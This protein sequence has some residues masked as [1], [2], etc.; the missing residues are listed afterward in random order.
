MLAARKRP[1]LLINDRPPPGLH[2]LQID[3]VSTDDYSG[4]V[5]AAQLIA[6]KLAGPLGSL[7]RLS[8]KQPT[9][10]EEKRVTSLDRKM[11]PHAPFPIKAPPDWKIAL[12]SGPPTDS[13]SNQR[14]AGF[15][16]L[17]PAN[18]T[19]CPSWFLE[20]ALVVAPRVLGSKPDAIFCCNVAIYF[21]SKVQATVFGHLYDA[22]R[23]GGLLFIGH[24][25]TLRLA[26][27]LPF[28]NLRIATYL[29][30]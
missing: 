10:I 2:S 24:A 19:S 13:R 5:C 12:F 22:L 14:I 16:S 3:S 15:I 26:G 11:S 20:D 6:Q 25:E 23:P 27:D 30:G 9:R 21:D 29:R 4:G 8:I 18:I 1:A 28:R 17:L 7:P